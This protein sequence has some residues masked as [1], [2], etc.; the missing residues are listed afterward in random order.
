M[1]SIII[2]VWLQTLLVGCLSIIAVLH[3]FVLLREIPESMLNYLFFDFVRR[4]IMLIRL[5]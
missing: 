1:T 4:V 3:H 2:F 5:V